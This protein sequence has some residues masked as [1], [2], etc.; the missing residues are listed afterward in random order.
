[1]IAE[2]DNLDLPR[3]LSLLDRLVEKHLAGKHDQRTH[4]GGGGMS[5]PRDTAHAK[6]KQAWELHEQGK[7]WEEVA[8]EAGYANGGAAR[9]AGKAHE[10]R[11][12]AKG[13][14]AEVPKPTEV[15]T[16]KPKTDKE[17]AKAIKDAQAVVD[18]A[19]G[20]RP[21]ADVLAEERKKGGTSKEPTPKELEVTEAVIQSGAILR[22][23]VDRRREV[24]GKD[25]VDKAKSEVE[26]L[27]KEREVVQKRVDE[28]NA[29][30]KE[31]RK[32]IEAEVMKSPEFDAELDERVAIAWG[33]SRSDAV[34][35]FIESDRGRAKQDVREFAELYNQ[36]MPYQ[37]RDAWVEERAR[38]RFPKDKKAQKEYKELLEEGIWVTDA[39]QRKVVER[40]EKVAKLVLED[41]SHSKVV[42]QA[43]QDLYPLNG[44]I[45]DREML[46]RNGG[47]TP[48]Q[49]AEIVR[50]VLIDS[51]RTMTDK[52]S[53]N[54][55][56]TKPVVAELRSELPKIP[57]ELWKDNMYPALK[58]EGVS[59]GRGH[60]SQY[61][62]RIKT[63]GDKGS[64][65]RAST[66]L[67][68]S[69][70]AVENMN[71]S[72]TNLQFVMFHRRAKGE[73]PQRL[74]D[75]DPRRGYRASETAVADKWTNAYSGKSYG[76]GRFQNYEIM[77]MGIESLYKRSNYPPIDEI[78]DDDHL[79]FTMG[80]LAYA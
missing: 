5:A 9:L 78:A 43:Y 8:K 20:G 10:K 72:V 24:A 13:E 64:G 32:V 77:T 36:G 30:Q 16:P 40:D 17:G 26:G 51:G 49:N 50:S 79:N 46:I 65:R 3:N 55:A 61:E 76:G 25:A 60:W 42:S 48:E 35:G 45:S 6:Q 7:T 73:K 22:S 67:H 41:K 57:D 12:K 74:K 18:K 66:L 69:M 38:Q 31:N 37:Q 80:V 1:M 75:L 70:H 52:P 63:D 2:L 15:V 27:T 34:D 68:E 71:S 23:E 53:Q 54:I 62:Q 59:R 29:I 4:G 44:A 19:T 47:V 33:R 39:A 11:M 58:V 14:G 28:L 56:G 21:V